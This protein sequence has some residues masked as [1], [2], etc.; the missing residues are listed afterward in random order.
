[1]RVRLA[2][3]GEKSR[4]MDNGKGGKAEEE[5]GRRGE[6]RG[7]PLPPLPLFLLFFLNYSGNA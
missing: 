6:Y 5:R 1:M 2:P 3:K 4:F 7:L